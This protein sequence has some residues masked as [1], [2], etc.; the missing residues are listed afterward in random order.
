MTGATKHAGTVRRWAGSW[1]GLT[2]EEQQ[3]IAAVLFLFV[4]GVCVRAWR[5]GAVSAKNAA[6]VTVSS[7]GNA[8]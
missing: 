3:V 5:G 6:P 2:R 1:F 8:T 7:G 4:L